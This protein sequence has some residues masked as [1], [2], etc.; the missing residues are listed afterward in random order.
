[1]RTIDADKLKDCFDI[2]CGADREVYQVAT[3]VY[4]FIIKIIDEQPTVEG[5]TPKTGKWVPFRR[6]WDYGKKRDILVQLEEGSDSEMEEY[7]DEEFMCTA[8]G[9]AHHKR[10]F[11]PHCGAKMEVENET[12]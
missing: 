6:V 2:A 1:M 7:W 5:G 9:Y 8:C 10:S 3:A 11:C 12:N 4:D